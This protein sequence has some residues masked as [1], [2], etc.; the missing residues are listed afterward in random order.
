MTEK[1]K[2]MDEMSKMM[3]IMSETIEKLQR[4]MSRKMN[5]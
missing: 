5:N 2:A 4:E 3:N 1:D